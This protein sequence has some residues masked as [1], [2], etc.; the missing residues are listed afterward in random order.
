MAAY[1]FRKFTTVFTFLCLNPSDIFQQPI[2][3]S[4]GSI[5]PISIR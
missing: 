1:F 5:D 4:I 2:Q 3:D